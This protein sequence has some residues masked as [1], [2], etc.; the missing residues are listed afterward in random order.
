MKAYRLTTGEG[1]DGLTRVDLPDPTP[2]PGEVVIRIRAT[3]LN[4]RDLGIARRSAAGVIPL[5]D[6][7]GEVVAAGEG[8]RIDVG[9]RVAGCFM[10]YWRDGEVSPEYQRDALGGMVDGVLAEQV[11]LPAASVVRL[12]DYLTFEEAATLPCAAVTAWNAM[13]EATRLKPG[14]TVLFLGTGGVSIFGLQLGVAAGMRTIVTSSSNAKLE[15][16]RAIGA[17]ETINYREREDWERAVLDLTGGRGVDL[18]L[19]VGGVGTFA[20][21]NVA[22]RHGGSIVVIG[23]LASAEGGA[24]VPLVGPNRL[25]T[26]ISVGSRRMFEDMN[27]ALEVGGVHPVIDRVFEFDQALEA[28]RYLESQ[29]H[30]GKVVVRV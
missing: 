14:S 13:F 4:Y 24:F 6:G 12:P 22:V 26:R 21:S 30:L 5:S 11:V 10:P 25:V 27:R 19:E 9:T 3:S 7:A 17:H 18:V 16:A 15:K 2:G 20:K 28:Y 23:G 29:Q 1:I 8:V